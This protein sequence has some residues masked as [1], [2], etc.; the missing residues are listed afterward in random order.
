MWFRLL[1]AAELTTNLWS[2]PGEPGLFH[3]REPTDARTSESCMKGA[4]SCCEHNEI[5]AEPIPQSTDIYNLHEG[6]GICM[7]TLTRG[8][9]MY[10]WTTCV[11]R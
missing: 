3:D 2:H 4:Q 1:S 5:D 6:G 11:R 9:F 10:K 8:S 7:L